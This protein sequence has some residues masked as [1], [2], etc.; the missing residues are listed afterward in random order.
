MPPLPVVDGPRTPVKPRT[1]SNGAC[2]GAAQLLARTASGFD[3]G[4]TSVRAAPE[5]MAAVRHFV[6]RPQTYL[7]DV[8]N[9]G[10]YVFSPSIFARI[11][12]GRKTSMNAILPVL[13]AQ[14]QLHSLLLSGYWTKIVDCKSFLAAVGPALEIA[15]FMTPS[16]LTKS[17][18]G[19]R[20]TIRGD[21]MVHET[22]RIGDG[23]ILGPCV[24][25]GPNCEVGEGVRMEGSTLLEGA[26]VRAHSLVKDSLVG[27]RCV[28][29]SW[30]HV[31][32][33][34]LG[35]EVSVGEALLVR[36]ATVLP[37][38]ELIESIRS[39]QIVI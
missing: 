34:V 35:E 11:E 10:V 33:T 7:S 19:G 20:Y 30:S 17:P 21:V 2:E 39:P 26:C 14:D 4:G 32:E 31:V 9:A 6:E 23:S 22:A 24:V 25:I 37:H 12:A 8:I 27:W 18:S 13:A 28:V 3:S 5:A 1:S 15:R 29:G 16:A 38:N 36:G